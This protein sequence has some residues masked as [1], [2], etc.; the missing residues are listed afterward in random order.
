MTTSSP[1]SW[2]PERRPPGPGRGPGSRWRQRC[3]S[4]ATRA[5]RGAGR[6]RV[7]LTITEPVFLTWDNLM[8]IVK[9]NSVIFVL[10][11]G[12]TFVVISGGIDLSIA[13]AT[14]A[15]AMIFGLAL[16]GG[17]WLVPALLAASASASRS[18]WPTAS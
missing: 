12:A 17:W 15:A 8:N 1:P 7:Y 10:A 6:R 4:A 16:H 2:R 13:S 14:T 5:C 9:S 11:I 3:R 18:V